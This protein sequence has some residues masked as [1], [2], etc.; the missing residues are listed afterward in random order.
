MEGDALTTGDIY[1][2][3]HIV[4]S[5][6]FPTSILPGPDNP[7][8]LWVTRELGPARPRPKQT[9]GVNKRA[10]PFLLFVDARIS[11]SET[12]FP[13]LDFPCAGL[14]SIL[15]F[16]QITDHFADLTLLGYFSAGGPHLQIKNSVNFLPSHSLHPSTEYK[17]QRHCAIHRQYERS[18][19]H[20][21]YAPWTPLRAALH[22]P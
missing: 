20:Q 14:G 7:R 18:N 16:S 1:L 5:R 10:F 21:W 4:C 19:Q 9:S 2:R 8:Q 3:R 22:P 6:C 15:R 11:P 12:A 13:L 17:H